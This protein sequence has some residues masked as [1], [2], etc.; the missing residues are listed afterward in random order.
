MGLLLECN[1]SFSRLERIEKEIDRTSVWKPYRLK[2]RGFVEELNSSS[3]LG[4]ND[5]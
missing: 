2:E 1:M 3:F 5:M 4:Q